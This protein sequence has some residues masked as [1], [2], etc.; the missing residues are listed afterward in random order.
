VWPPIQFPVKKKAARSQRKGSEFATRANRIIFTIRF[1][2]SPAH[3]HTVQPLAD[4]IV[5]QADV[6]KTK[7]HLLLRLSRLR[8]RTPFEI[9]FRRTDFVWFVVSLSFLVPGSPFFVSFGP[10]RASLS[11]RTRPTPPSFQWVWTYVMRSYLS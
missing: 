2:F 4:R 10:V 8:E 9:H 1:D 7:K 3:S 5:S 6:N 11:K